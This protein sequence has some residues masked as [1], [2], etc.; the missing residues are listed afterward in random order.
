MV[1]MGGTAFYL[2]SQIF[3]IAIPWCAALVF[4]ILWR[5]QELKTTQKEVEHKI[6]RIKKLY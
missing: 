1:L 2:M 6:K 4:F 3:E 5:Y